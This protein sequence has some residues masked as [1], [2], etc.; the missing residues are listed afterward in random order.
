[1]DME[2]AKA[3]GRAGE[4]CQQYPEEDAKWYTMHPSIHTFY[5]THFNYIINDKEIVNWLESILIL[6]DLIKYP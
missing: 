6:L 5:S 4:S 2:R 1:M 3:K